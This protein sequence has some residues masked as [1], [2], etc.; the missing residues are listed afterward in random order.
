MATAI[1]SR[2]GR[3]T[4]PA[5]VRAALGARPGDRF[6]FLEIAKGRYEL[7]GVTRPV[8]ALKGLCAPACRKVSI[9]EMNPLT[10]KPR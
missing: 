6:E 2:K 9:E 5:D 8:T 7:I 4:V 1:L 3:I 10:A